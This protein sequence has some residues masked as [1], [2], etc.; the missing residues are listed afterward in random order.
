MGNACAC[1]ASGQ[2]DPAVLQALATLDM[3]QF[4]D[5]ICGLGVANLDD[6]ALLGESGS[7]ELGVINWE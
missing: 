4:Y 2:A 5:P 6:L 1:E 7:N 3:E